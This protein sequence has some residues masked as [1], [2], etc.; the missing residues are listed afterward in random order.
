MLIGSIIGMATV[1]WG[2]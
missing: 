2:Y 1:P